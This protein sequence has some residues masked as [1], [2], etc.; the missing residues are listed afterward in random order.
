MIDES[1]NIQT[2]IDE[3]RQAKKRV[4]VANKAC[5]ECIYAAGNIRAIDDEIAQE[6]GFPECVRNAT[7]REQGVQNKPA[8][9]L[10]YGFYYRHAQENAYLRAARKADLVTFYD[11]VGLPAVDPMQPIDFVWQDEY[12]KRRAD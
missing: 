9:V 12:D 2:F 4:Y 3:I 5:A 7:A 8:F 11:I 1:A 6:S 10:C